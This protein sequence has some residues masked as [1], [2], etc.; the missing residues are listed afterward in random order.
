[1]PRWPDK[2]VSKV[3][4]YSSPE[5]EVTSEE[6]ESRELKRVRVPG[7]IFEADETG[8]LYIPD[9]LLKALFDK[10]RYS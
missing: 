9:A 1:M 5:K 4:D 8:K 10:K 2:T 3:E 7:T 6:I